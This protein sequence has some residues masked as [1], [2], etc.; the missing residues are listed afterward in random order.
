M[1]RS[2]TITGLLVSLI[3]FV[4]QESDI[5][6]TQNDLDTFMTILLQIGGIFMAWYGRVRRGDITLFGKRK[7]NKDV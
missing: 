7:I 3:G 1:N 4:L 6:V 2:F 5:D